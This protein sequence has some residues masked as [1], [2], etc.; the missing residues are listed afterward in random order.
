MRGIW[1]WVAIALLLFAAVWALK[2]Q[3]RALDDRVATSR[4]RR[5]LADMPWPQVEQVIADYVR[6][7]DFEVA[8]T[9][10]A[11][12]DAAADVLLTRLNEYYLLRPRY[13]RDAT[14]GV[15]AVREFHRAM[16]A[17]HAVGGFIITSG[18]FSPEARELARE[19][20]IEL[21]D[22]EQVAPVVAQRRA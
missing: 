9:E 21:V 16:A 15:E 13:W 7:R 3:R 12:P 11:P 18:S 2:R 10:R 14:V 19:R 4:T 22:G 17:R 1:L 5:A 6:G 8:E 20:Q